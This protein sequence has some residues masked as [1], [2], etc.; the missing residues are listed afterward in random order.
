MGASNP[1]PGGEPPVIDPKQNPGG[2]DPT[3][4][5]AGAAAG[6]FDPSKLSDD[7]LAKLFD[8]SRLYNHARFKK[9]S[10]EAKEAK[11]LKAEKAAA[12]E[13]AL[14]EKGEWEKLAKKRESELT[15][16]QQ[17]IKET[18][19]ESAIKDA[20]SKRGIKDLDAAIKLIDKSKVVVNEDGSISGIAEAVE[21]LAKE[22]SY[23]L[24]VNRSSIGSPTNPGETGT[25]VKFKMSQIGNPAFYRA[26]EKAI[27]EA[28]AAGQVEE[29][30][31]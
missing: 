15:T 23:L 1:N 14:K 20:A 27:K 28:L 24:T 5:G 10:D 2:A 6:S 13:A 8:D 21:A 18:T 4:N 16:L 26:N 30:R 7:D 17:K 29:D 19:V 25:G 3:K 22:R 11:T 9:L 12:E 31:R